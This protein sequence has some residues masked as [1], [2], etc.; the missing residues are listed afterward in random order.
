MRRRSSHAAHE[1][2]GAAGD[3]NTNGL[4]HHAGRALTNDSGVQMCGVGRGFAGVKSF[5]SEGLSR[6]NV[7]FFQPTYSRGQTPMDDM[8]LSLIRCWLSRLSHGR[9]LRISALEPSVPSVVATTVPSS[10]CPRLWCHQVIGLS[11]LPAIYHLATRI[12]SRNV[13]WHTRRNLQGGHVTVH[14]RA[15]S[16]LPHTRPPCWGARVLSPSRPSNRPSLVNGTGPF[17]RDV[18]AAMAPRCAAAAAQPCMPRGM[19]PKQRRVLCASRPVA[20]HAMPC[21][22]AR[23]AASCM[24]RGCDVGALL[25]TA[26]NVPRCLCQGL[27]GSQHLGLPLFA[28]PPFLLVGTLVIVHLA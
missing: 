11:T 4:V 17:R 20:R 15:A 16:S 3:T 12:I 1:A 10:L 2:Y 28:T 5:R 19:P 22:A 27:A 25:W 18:A 23:H 9:Q 13:I 7:A 21:Y 6:P 24:P 26:R 8:R 14:V